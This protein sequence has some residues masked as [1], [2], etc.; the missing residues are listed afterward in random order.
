MTEQQRQRDRYSV[1]QDVDVYDALRDVYIGRLVNLH[2]KG[3][4]LIADVPLV[5]DALYTLDIHLPRPINNLPSMQLGVDCLWVREA[6]L[7][8]KYWMGCSIIDATPD[9][10]NII[11]QLI[12]TDP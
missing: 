11:E 1:S 4:M 7:S 2:S 10:L 6:D 12:K 9:A 8:G 5:E 3:L